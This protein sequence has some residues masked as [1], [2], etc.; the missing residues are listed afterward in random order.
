MSELCY[1][2]ENIYLIDTEE[3]LVPKLI[4]AYFTDEDKETLID[5]GS[6]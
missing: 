1:I 5:T 4:A 2:T 6:D 3:G